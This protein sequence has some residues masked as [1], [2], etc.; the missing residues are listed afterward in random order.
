VSDGCDEA[1]TSS[2]DVG[3]V[4]GPV[5]AVTKCFAQIG[6]MHPK[7]DFFHDDVGPDPVDQFLP[8]H[9]VPRTLDKND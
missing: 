4:S 9:D 3:H 8:A 6:D 7:I 2:G 1:I 5:A